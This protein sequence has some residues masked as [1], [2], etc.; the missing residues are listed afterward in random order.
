M[1]ERV[2]RWSASV[3]FLV[4]AG[5]SG[6]I[7]LELS[8]ISP[9]APEVTAGPTGAPKLELAPDPQPFT[10]PPRSAFDDRVEHRLHIRR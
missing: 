3:W 6:V 2:A 4:C 7:G 9:L 8:G 1:G 10:P 5:L